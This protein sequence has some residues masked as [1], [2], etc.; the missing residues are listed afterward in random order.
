MREVGWPRVDERQRDGEAAID[1]GLLGGDP[2]EVVEPRQAA[3]FD[4]E[5]EILE[6]GGDVVDV[7]TWNASLFNG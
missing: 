7:A 6:R 2:A 5:V 1:V 3:M 4:D